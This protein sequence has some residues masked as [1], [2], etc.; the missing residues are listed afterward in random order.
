MSAAEV[1]L[2]ETD[3][4]V[5]SCAAVLRELRPALSE[6]AMVEQVAL[7]RGEGYRLAMLRV[8]GAVMTVAGFRV[9][10]MLATGKTMYVDDLVTAAAGRSRGYGATMLRWLLELARTEGCATFS[11]DSGTQRKEAHAFYLRERLRITS[12]HFAMP[13][14]GDGQG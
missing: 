2:A 7:Q 4:A 5:R 8:D 9:Q 10:H 11:L 6:A 14:A 3:V 1:F 13:L 12:F